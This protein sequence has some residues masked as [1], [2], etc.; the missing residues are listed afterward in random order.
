MSDGPGDNVVQIASRPR[1]VSLTARES[2]P[3]CDHVRVL[4][5]RE[6]PILECATCGAIVDPY[7]WIRRLTRE[8]ET[9]DFH[10]Q[11]QTRIL[12]KLQTVIAANGSVRIAGHD[13]TAVVP[14]GLED[15]SASS[16]AS[17]PDR[18]ERACEAALDRCALKRANTPK[19]IL[20]PAYY[21]LVRRRGPDDRARYFVTLISG[22]DMTSVLNG[23]SRGWLSLTEARLGAEA[24]AKKRGIQYREV[25]GRKRA[26]P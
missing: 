18:I 14:I 4:I 21:N 6:Q 2:K 3:R 24:D 26:R 7:V 12:D 11:Q 19:E 8:W 22:S 5:D 10:G 17:W 16:S 15:V 23:N 1:P 9:Y 13:V 20:S 25:L